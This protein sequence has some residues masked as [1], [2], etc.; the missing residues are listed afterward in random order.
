MELD[1]LQVFGCQLFNVEESTLIKQYIDLDY[2]FQLF[3]SGYYHVCR[4]Y[5]F[6]DAMEGDFPLNRVIPPVAVGENVPQQPNPDVNYCMKVW[7]M[8][9]D[10]NDVPTSCWTHNIS[11]RMVMWKNFTPKYGACIKTTV[12]RVVNSIRCDEYG[13]MCGKM[14]YKGYFAQRG[15][16]DNLFSKMPEYSEEEECRFYFFEKKKP[17]KQLPYVKIK[18]DPAALVQEVILSPFIN[19][20]TSEKLSEF[21][22]CQYN[23]KNVSPSKIK[24]KL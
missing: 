13:I 1:K 11:D 24:M 3:E 22:K 17:E 18:V 9:Q 21:I 2:L 6:N 12:G 10:N 15:F 14:T 8:L 19:R 7:R 23:I 4:K 16:T 5:M 20:K